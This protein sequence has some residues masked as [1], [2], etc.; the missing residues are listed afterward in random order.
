[1]WSETV[2][3]KF[4]PSRKRCRKSAGAAQINVR[5]VASMERSN[6]RILKPPTSRAE[7]CQ[8]D[9]YDGANHNALQ[10]TEQ[11]A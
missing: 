4:Q 10:K 2:R 5:P 8:C 7:G 1:M 6:S 11:S 9:Y 3:N